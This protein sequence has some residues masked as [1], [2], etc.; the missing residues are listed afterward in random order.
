MNPCN[1]ASEIVAVTSCIVFSGRR[2]QFQL[3]LVLLPAAAA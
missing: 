3:N 2:E 1:K